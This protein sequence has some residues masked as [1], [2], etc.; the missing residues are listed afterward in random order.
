MRRKAFLANAILWA[1]A[2]VGSAVVGAPP[3]FSTAVLPTLAATALL[4][5]WPSARPAE[6][7]G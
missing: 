4:V 6:F 3:F 2:I 5:S 7:Q 1:A